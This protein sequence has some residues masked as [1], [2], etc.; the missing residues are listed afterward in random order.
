MIDAYEQKPKSDKEKAAIMGL[1][2]DCISV[3]EAAF[4]GETSGE[5]YLNG[6][7]RRLEN[8]PFDCVIAA[9]K[10]W[11]EKNRKRPMWNDLK[12]EITEHNKQRNR[13]RMGIYYSAGGYQSGIK[14]FGDK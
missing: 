14:L 2:A 3:C 13:M 6:M 5:L 11:P 10:A 1:F 8:E 7:V 12:A 9:I 4:G